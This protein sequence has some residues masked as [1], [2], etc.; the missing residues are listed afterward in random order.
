MVWKP[1]TLTLQQKAH[2]RLH[3]A[4]NAH[5]MEQSITQLAEYYGVSTS[6]IYYW[7]RRLRQSPEGLLS[8][9]PTGRPR[10][11]TSDQIEHLQRWLLQPATDHGFADPTWTAS[12]A[13]D[14]VGLKF[15]VWYH[16]N[17]V[18]KLLRSLGFSYQRPDKWAIER[19]ENKI[20]G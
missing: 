2:R 3:F 7:K 13:R 5:L 10:R 19:D 8:T 6:G 14:I 20:A 9:K 17:H 12:R 16:P 1:P 4:E 11:L 18:A 15:G